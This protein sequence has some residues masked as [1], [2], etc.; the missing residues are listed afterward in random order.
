MKVTNELFLMNF[1]AVKKSLTKIKKRKI[2]FTCWFFNRSREV[3]LIV[4]TLA[5]TSPPLPHLIAILVVVL[6]RGMPVTELVW[7][8]D[9]GRATRPLAPVRPFA[10]RHYG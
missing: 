2:V 10:T 1:T 8:F 9:M 6:S 7:D 3:R 5:V 4:G